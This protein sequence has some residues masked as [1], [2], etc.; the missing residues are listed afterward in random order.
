MQNEIKSEKIHVGKIFS[1][2]WFRIPEY[3]RPYVW[4][5]D[6]IADILDDISYALLKKPNSEYFLGSFVFQSHEEIN[7]ENIAFTENDLLDGQQR[8]TTLLLLFSVLR[9]LAKDNQAIESCQKCIFQ[10]GNE[11]EGIPERSRIVFDIRQEAQDFVD[12]LAKEIGFSVNNKKLSDFTEK[13]TD[14]SVRNMACAVQ[15]IVAFFSERTDILP[16]NFIKFLRNNVVFIYVST[17]NLEDAFRLFTILNDR[18]IPLRNSDILKS[19]NLGALGSENEKKKYAELWEKAESEMGEDF[20]RF[21]S[22][23][24]TIL[25]KE[26]ARLSLLQEYEDRIYDPKDKDKDKNKKLPLLTR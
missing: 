25:V 11:Y 23:L 16:E 8:I 3:Q 21:L 7:N 15:N 17:E 22:H 18:G 2:M 14:L 6:Q 12:I 19:V 20:D 10:Q 9:D 4:G 5:K 13:A 1:E 24:R 26:K